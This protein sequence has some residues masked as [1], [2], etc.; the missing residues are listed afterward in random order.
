MSPVAAKL[1]TRSKF[2]SF[3]WT[4]SEHAKISRLAA[5]ARMD[6]TQY[7]V[8]CALQGLSAGDL[9]TGEDGLSERMEQLEGRVARLEEYSDL[10]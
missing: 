1:E 8:R 3:R 5:K 9:A 4:E 6:L 2:V 7:V 10:G